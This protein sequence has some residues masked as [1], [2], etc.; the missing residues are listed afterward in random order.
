MK[1]VYIG[2]SQ[3]ATSVNAVYIS[4]LRAVGVEVADFFSNRSYIVKYL[5]C[6]RFYFQ[7]R[8][9]CNFVMV[10][11]DC[12][13][14]VFFMKIIIRKPIIW[15]A[16]CS[17]YERL[18]VSR[19]LAGRKSPK[20][21]YYWLVDYLAAKAAKI[22]MLESQNQ[23]EY[24][25]RVFKLNRYKAFRAWTGTNEKIFF[26]D[27]LVEK[28]KD[29]TIVFRG[30][31]LPEAGGEYVVR[32]AKI[33]ESEGIQFLMLAFGQE[34]PKIKSLIAEL[35]PKN[36]QLI[37]SPLSEENLRMFMLQ[38]HLSLGQLS[39]HERLQRTIPHKAYESLALKLPY[40]TA[41]NPGILELLEEGKTCLACNPADAEDL[42]KKIKW[43]KDHP[44][45]ILEISER[46]H[47]FYQHNLSPE[48]L[49]QHLLRVL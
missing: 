24:F 11:V 36:L 4:G 12:P 23:I 7:N 13:E 31:L 42:A 49:S 41:R 27:P 48:I 30:R 19:G 22:V 43:A 16:L 34:L 39:N 35:H 37:D 8:K 21:V 46:A 6:A 14:L 25:K 9:N 26:Y 38:S 20:A 47:K 40:L 29:F 5:D 15:N 18:I 10:G 3:N 44:N 32:A 1:V 45:E 17:V 33:L 28:S 2:F